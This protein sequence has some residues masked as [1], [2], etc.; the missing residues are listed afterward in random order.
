VQVEAEL[1]RFGRD[2]I[3]LEAAVSRLSLEPA[4]SSVSWSIVEDA[5]AVLTAEQ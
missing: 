2:D 5:G 1:Q 4:V 3:G